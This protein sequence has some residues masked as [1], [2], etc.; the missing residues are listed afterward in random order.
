MVYEDE[1]AARR[2][3]EEVTSELVEKINDRK[4]RWAELYS[5][6]AEVE[7]DQLWHAGGFRSMTKWMEELARIAKCNIQYLWRIKKAGG[8]YVR[9]AAAEKA[10]GREVVPVEELTLGDEML[11][12]IDRVADGDEEKAREYIGAALDGTLTKSKVKDM[13]RAT[14]GTRRK[15]RE[16]RKAAAAGEAPAPAG[17]EDGA[18]PGDIVLALKPEVFYGEDVAA[19]HLLHGARRVWRVFSEF[20]VRTGTSDRARRMDALC[21]SNAGDDDQYDLM[22][23][24]VEIKVTFAD[25]KRDTKHLEYENFADRCWFAVPESMSYAAVQACP[26]G[27]GVLVWSPVS[28]RLRVE[29]EAEALRGMLR[30]ETMATALVKT[31]PAVRQG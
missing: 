6:M 27:W 10:A 20:P 1:A 31:L 29:V 25:L 19:R 21:M 9:F 15:A 2:K 8:F 5:L 18:T 13:V 22:L 16:A 23:D 11:A 28:R 30:A 7:G 24:M 26:D 4:A 17:G 3:L 12:D 14:A